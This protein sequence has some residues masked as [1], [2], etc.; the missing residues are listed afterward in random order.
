[1]TFNIGDRV[2]C[3]YGCPQGLVGTV[4]ESGC[5]T[6]AVEFDEEFYGAHSCSGLTAVTRG[7]YCKNDDVVLV[8]AKPRM[9]A[10]KVKCVGYN[11]HERYFELGKIYEVTNN[12]TMMVNEYGNVYDKPD[13]LAYLKRWYK[14][15]IVEEIE[16]KPFNCVFYLTENV[17]KYKKNTRYE[18]KDGRF[19][20]STKVLYSPNDL[21]SVFGRKVLIAEIGRPC[22]EN[23]KLNCRIRITSNYDDILTEGTIVD[24]VDGKFKCKNGQHT[25]YPVKEYLTDLK[26]LDSYFRIGEAKRC[27][28]YFSANTIN[29]EVI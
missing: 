26:H 8:E 9:V 14:F 7:W 1:M 13:V 22:I 23:G 21:Y 2:R 10:T 20:H 29:Y 27:A 16:Y 12:G 17:G 18:V 15:E 11:L 19:G 28:R 3:I 25:E 4:K 6:F 24:I 5:S